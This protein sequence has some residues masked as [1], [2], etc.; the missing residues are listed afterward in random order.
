MLAALAGGSLWTT[1]FAQDFPEF[2]ELGSLDGT[3]GFII[4]AE[5]DHNWLGR[6]VSAAGDINNDGYDDLLIGAPGFNQRF[7]NGTDQGRTYVL[8]GRDDNFDSPF[9]LSTIDGSNGSALDGELS[10]DQSGYSVGN[11]GDVDGDGIDDLII[12]AFGSDVNG[13]Q[14]GRSY[15]VYGSSFGFP[16]ET[17]ALATLDEVDDGFKLDG[18]A[19]N[20]ESGRSVSGIGDFNDDGIDDFIIGAHGSDA[21][22]FSSGRS[23]VVFGKVGGLPSPLQ[24]ASLDGRNGFKVDGEGLL[25]EAGYSVSAAGDV[26]GDGVDDII[27]G[28][29]FALDGAEDGRSYVLFGTSKPHSETFSLSNLNGSNGFVIDGLS[30]KSKSGY[31]VSA[32]GDVNNDGFGDVIIGAPKLDINGSGGPGNEHGGAYV[33]FGKAGAF[34]KSLP[35]TS[36][37]GSNGFRLD[38]EN[39]DDRA[40]KSVAGAGDVNGDGYDDL[41]VGATIADPDGPDTGRAY[42]VFGH[43]GGFSAT[44]PLA[45]LDGTNGFKL[46]GEWDGDRAGISVAGIGDI[47][48][49][50]F[51][52]IAV[53]AHLFDKVGETEAG[54]VYVIY[55]RA[56]STPPPSEEPTVLFVDSFEN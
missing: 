3:D 31:S 49:D 6:S 35:L 23:Y 19:K 29:P 10:L 36:L 44:L 41:I 39:L 32:A 13:D 22:D 50:G 27:I 14:S 47:N 28:A 45:G 55:G 21:V 37:D 46:D 53:G 2:I 11:A 20:D 5:M 56:T 52:D 16:A 30:T 1:A 26:N 42:V 38:G 9:A 54:R 12:G 25:S 43:P 33:V 4:D 17:R 51:D 15:V 40:G 48:N 24:L 34:S 7:G 8:F 18:E